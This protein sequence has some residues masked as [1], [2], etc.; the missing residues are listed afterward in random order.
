MDK[1]AASECE[2]NRYRR[3]LSSNRVTS[4]WYREKAD[5]KRGEGVFCGQAWKR[6]RLKGSTLR[7]VRAGEG[8]RRRRRED[9]PI[10][11]V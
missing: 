7:D 2:A 4:E 10:E 11:G 6:K 1:C 5:R 9:G 8:R 3:S